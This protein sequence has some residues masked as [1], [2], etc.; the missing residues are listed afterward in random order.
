VFRHPL[1]GIFLLLSLCGLAAAAP[2]RAGAALD[3]EEATLTITLERT[4]EGPDVFRAEF[5]VI[6]DGLNNGTLA[7][8]SQ[9]AVH[10]V[11]TKVG[12]DLVG[13]R[14]FTTEAELNAVITNGNYVLRVNNA[15]A[16]ATIPFTRPVVPNPAISH[17]PNGVVPPGP[18]EVEFTRCS[19]CNLVGDSVVAVLENG[20]GTVLDESVDLDDD[21]ESW[22]PQEMGSDRV[23]PEASAFV[24]RVTHTAVRQD[25][26][27]VN[28]DDDNNLLF[29][30]AV[31]HSD[32][33][34]FETGF[35]PPSGAFCLAA[36]F[37]APPLG[38]HALGDDALALFDTG[39]AFSIQVD[40]HDVDVSVDPVAANGQLTGTANADLDDAGGN[41]TMGAIKGKLSGRGG[42]AKQKLSFPLVNEGL[43]AKLKVSLSD[44]LS[45][46]TDT[47]E[48]VLKSSGAIGD[49]RVRELV[50]STDTPLPTAPRGWL[51]Q[52]TLNPDST[53]SSALLTLEGGRTFPLTANNRFNFSTNQSNVKLTSDPKGISINL[54]KL[55][56]D[57]AM[58][59]MD[60]T[61]G[62]LSYK[63]LGQSGKAV[64]P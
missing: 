21:S 13:T 50:E 8:P 9:P 17:P 38:C 61:G 16:Q 64:L 19:V 36:N 39:G 55:G 40:G 31:V 56:L 63:A 48:R 26:I 27:T 15:S 60:I 23:L 33:V 46:P 53:V 62:S 35:N 29:S 32:E 25:N 24:V 7:V 4:T 12:N 34:G 11:L 43:L 44:V 28:T 37:P 51:L 54:K 1:R 52:Y 3:I 30:G 22:V 49:V 10:G 20:V 14:V 45:I 2:A 18:I 58:N 57:D 41:E 42:E 5:R 47:R 59:P 6:G